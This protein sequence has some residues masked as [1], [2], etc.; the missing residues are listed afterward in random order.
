MAANREVRPWTCEHG[1]VLGQ[2]FRN[3][4]KVRVLALYRNAVN[5]HPNPLPEGE[6][7]EAME[8][9]EVFGVVEGYV[10]DIRCS[11]CG[12]VRSWVPGEESLK[13]LMERRK[14]MYAAGN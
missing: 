3:G 7:E 10:A 12:C 4:N 5:P 13:L 8:E 11:I 6:G 1:H 9:V 14:R 2:V